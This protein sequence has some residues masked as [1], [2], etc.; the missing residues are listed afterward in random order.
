MS[1]HFGILCIKGL[2]NP[3]Y[4]KQWILGHFKTYIWLGTFRYNCTWVQLIKRSRDKT[5][6]DKEIIW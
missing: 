6:I 4:I 2:I 3:K 5:K 1:D